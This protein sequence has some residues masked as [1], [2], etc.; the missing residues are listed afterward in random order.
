M[1]RQFLENF[2]CYRFALRGLFRRS[3]VSE[4][5]IE[6]KNWEQAAEVNKARKHALEKEL[7]LYCLCKRRPFRTRKDWSPRL[8]HK[9]C[10]W[11]LIEP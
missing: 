6:H 1:D 11:K 5:D 4:D 3:V 7:C 10:Y 8:L 9:A 2:L